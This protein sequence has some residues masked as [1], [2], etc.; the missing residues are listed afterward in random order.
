MTRSGHFAEELKTVASEI[1][2]RKIRDESPEDFLT[3]EQIATLMKVAEPT[4]R[5]WIKSGALRAARPAAGGKPGRVYRIL[6]ADLDEF[7]GGAQ[8]EDQGEID[9]KAEAA[10]IVAL[11]ARR[12]K[13]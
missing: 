6:R 10:R 12:P 5:D 7:V 4:V 8:G 1:A 9:V 11:S 3:V 2:R 13:I